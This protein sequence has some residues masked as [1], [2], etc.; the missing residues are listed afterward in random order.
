MDL[1][2]W[3]PLLPKQLC[4]SVLPAFGESWVNMWLFSRTPKYVKSTSKVRKKYVFCTYPNV[5]PVPGAYFPVQGAYFP[6]QKHVK[7]TYFQGF[8][9]W[10][11][12][13]GKSQFSSVS[14]CFNRWFWMDLLQLMDFWV[15]TSATMAP[16]CLHL[17]SRAVFKA[18]RCLRHIGH[19]LFGGHAWES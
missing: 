13:S 3:F 1:L 6:V 9:G 19:W 4:K 10:S 12:N 15:V 14:R 7:S 11:W 17:W 18:S 5:Y 16:A 8:L 2:W